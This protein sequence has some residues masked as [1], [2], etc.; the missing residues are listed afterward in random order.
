M[1]ELIVCLFEVIQGLEEFTFLTPNA[2]NEN[3]RTKQPVIPHWEI[4]FTFSLI[5]TILFLIWFRNYFEVK[6]ILYII[7]AVIFGIIV[8][9]ILYVI[10]INLANFIYLKTIKRK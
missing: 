6:L 2:R 9:G 8:W 7:F 1:D 5:V 10:I 4:F 3:R